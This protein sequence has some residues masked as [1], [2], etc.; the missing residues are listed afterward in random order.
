MRSEDY[1]VNQI[2]YV[3]ESIIYLHKLVQDGDFDS[4]RTTPTGGRIVT[5]N[6]TPYDRL[7]MQAF[8]DVEKVVMCYGK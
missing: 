1:I 6:I 4:M 7:T 2:K 3:P 8:K 5:I